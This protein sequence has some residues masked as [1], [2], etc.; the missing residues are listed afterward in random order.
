MTRI[1][2]LRIVSKSNQTTDLERLYA[3][4][5]W[6]SKILDM[7]QQLLDDK[8]MNHSTVK[9]YSAMV[10]VQQFYCFDKRNFTSRTNLSSG[11]SVRAAGC[12]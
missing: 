8:P 9:D 5:T 4:C 1:A 12:C 6:Y 2:L 10:V 3:R 7:F 11:H